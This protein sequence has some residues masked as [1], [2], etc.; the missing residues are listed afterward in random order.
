[1]KNI[2]IDNYIKTGEPLD[3]AGSYAVQGIGQKFIRE[4][5]GDKLAAIGLPLQ[6]IVDFLKLRDF[7]FSGEVLNNIQNDSVIS[8]NPNQNLIG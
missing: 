8:S 3:K 6:T 4:L 1:M 2:E 5:K 7:N